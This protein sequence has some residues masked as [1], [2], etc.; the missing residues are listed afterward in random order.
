MRKNIFLGVV[1]FLTW[2]FFFVFRMDEAV[3]EKPKEN[4]V[5]KTKSI[6]VK[7]EIVSLLPQSTVIPAKKEVAQLETKK[8]GDTCVNYISDGTKKMC[9]SNPIPETIKNQATEG[10][11]QEFTEDT[12]FFDPIPPG[13]EATTPTK[14]IA[15][16]GEVTFMDPEMMQSETA[17]D[18]LGNQDVPSQ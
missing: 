7:K 4:A 17:S 10:N 6:E 3:P 9:L 14:S 16:R 11:T 13:Y 2:W 1:I 8:V 12:P 5:V 15:P 18:E